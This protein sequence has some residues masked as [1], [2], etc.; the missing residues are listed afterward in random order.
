MGTSVIDA[1]YRIN[2]LLAT[3][4]DVMSN[5]EQL[6]NAAGCWLTYDIHDGKWSFVINKTATT[7]KT[8]N[9]SNIIGSIT[10]SGTG[11]NDLYN[12]VKVEFPHRDLRDQI[13]FVEIEIPAADRNSN[14][15][16]NTLNIKYDII[17]DPVQA[18]LL[19]F[20]ELKQSRVD[21]VIRFKT[22]F[23]SIGLKAGDLIDVT[24]SIYGFTNKL[25]R[26]VTIGE[27]DGDDGSIVLDITALE[28]DSSVYDENL[29]SYTR[30]D[31]NGIRAIG[32]I[33]KPSAPT[34]TKFEA[35]AR[36]HLLIEAT[37]PAGVVDGIEYWLSADNSSFT[38]IGTVKPVN[39]NTFTSGDQV[40]FDYSSAPAGN[41]Y[42]KVRATNN[43]TSSDFSNVSSLTYAP[44]QV[45][46]QIGE[47]TTDSLGNLIGPLAL[48]ALLNS[49]NGLFEGNSGAGS[50]IGTIGNLL[51][52]TGGAVTSLNAGNNIVL[53]NSTGAVTISATG[54]GGDGTWE[55][56]S[57]FVS[58]TTPVGT[59]D[60][61]DVWFKIP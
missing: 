20:I 52:S 54:G 25:F 47:N 43:I 9:D 17:N 3:E 37:S 38:Q 13:D 57:R 58:S 32:S 14:E 1:R 8:F 48:A 60:N 11:L 6:C 51:T 44:V 34:L 12:K 26:V 24:N 46:D 18:E 15:P 42:V 33:A 23:S 41:V 21:K 49:L 53:S 31:A 39:G 35:N 50:M 16:D 36:P 5:M 40:E 28:Y 61:G 59:F 30:T 56:A 2:G 27:A 10:I 4:K 22:D 55:G 19:G 45:T 29:T 7:S